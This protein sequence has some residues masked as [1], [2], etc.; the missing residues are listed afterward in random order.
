LACT[1]EG[2]AAT[3][4]FGA[5]TEAVADLMAMIE[6][7]MADYEN[8]GVIV[9][10]V[11]G[12][13]Y[14]SPMATGAEQ[15]LAFLRALDREEVESIGGEI[16]ELFGDVMDDVSTGGLEVPTEI[17]EGTGA[18]PSEGAG[19]TTV[20]EPTTPGVTID[21]EGASAPTSSPAGSLPD[22]SAGDECYAAQTAV[23]ATACFE[24]LIA[25][26]ELAPSAVP[27]YL[28]APQCGLDV[29]DLERLED[30]RL[31]EVPD[32]ALR[33][34]RDRDG[35]LDLADPVRVGHARDAAL[36]A[37]VG[38]DALEPHHRDR[39]SLLGHAGLVGVDHVHDHPALE[40]LGETRLDPH[41]SELE[42]GAQSTPAR[43]G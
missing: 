32:A 27:I 26:G 3:D 4:V 5:D 19:P 15:A 28:R 2:S 36:G 20:P 42:H 7:A 12:T 25:T 30:L 29:V 10:Q 9:Q 16:A 8:P 39:P 6:A 23:D 24:A 43:R 37:D 18:E 33:H 41:R 34:H 17:L 14:L 31:D 1:L 11:D 38:R 22:S 35:L 13:W 40:H 21:E